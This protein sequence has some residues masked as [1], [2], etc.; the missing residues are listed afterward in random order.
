MY[1]YLI[2]YLMLIIIATIF[3]G[4][5][6]SNAVKIKFSFDYVYKDLLPIWTEDTMMQSES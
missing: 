6:V 1:M 4:N 5:A 3:I 2:L